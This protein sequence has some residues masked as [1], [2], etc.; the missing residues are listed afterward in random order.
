[1]DSPRKL[2]AA[3]SLAVSLCGLFVVTQR[4]LQTKPILHTLWV[5]APFTVT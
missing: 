5:Q 2:Q 4:I 1:M 3:K